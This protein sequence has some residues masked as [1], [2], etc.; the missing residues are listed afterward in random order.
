MYRFIETIHYRN[1]V[2]RN[3]EYHNERFNRTRKEFCKCHKYKKIEDIITIPSGLSSTNYKCRLIYGR[4][5]E[6]TEFLP[7]KLKEIGKL[8]LVFDDAIEYSWKYKDREAIN[9]LM[10][11]RGECDDILIVKNGLLSD[12]SY[13]NL[14]FGDGTDWYTPA[15]PLLAGTMR[16]SL[17]DRGLLIPK[18]I[19]PDDLGKYSHIRLINAM[20]D[21]EEGICLDTASIIV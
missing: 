17:I 19:T 7:Y 11:Q 14:A 15:Q 18:D 21:L 10:E 3:M 16:A 13:A 9:R 12:S 4:L 5:I 1:G 8:R 2:L 20:M 6:K